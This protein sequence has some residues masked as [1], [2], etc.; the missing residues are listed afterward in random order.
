MTA[1][2]EMTLLRHGFTRFSAL[3]CCGWQS[4]WSDSE[5]AVAALHDAHAELAEPIP[6][7]FSEEQGS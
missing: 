7:N 2:H 5:D 6:P 1:D 3:C 4:P